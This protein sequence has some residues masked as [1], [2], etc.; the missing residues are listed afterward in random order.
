M[1]SNEPESLIFVTGNPG[2]LREAQAF[3][4]FTL[5]GQALDLPE[6]QT[7]DAKKLVHHKTLAAFEA[8]Q[9][10]IFVEDTFLVFSAWG[11][12]PGPYIK[13]FLGELGLEGLVRALS[14][15]GNQEALASCHIGYHD[16]RTVHYFSGTVAGRIVPPKG[17][18]GFGWDAIFAPL[19]SEL[20]FGEMDLE[21]KALYSMRAKA[22]QAFA[23]FLRQ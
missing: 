20:T 23:D 18:G 21:E 1:A 13:D 19:G 8:L 17:S 10:P 3:L 6:I 12:L 7:T 14:P 15:F 4:P 9:G 5:Q 11:N 16:G 22:L 2:K